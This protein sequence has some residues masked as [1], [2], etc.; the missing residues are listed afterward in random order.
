MVSGPARPNALMERSVGEV[1]LLVG[2]NQSSMVVSTISRHAE[3]DFGTPR[4]RGNIQ[5]VQLSIVLGGR[6]KVPMERFLERSKR[7]PTV[8]KRSK[9]VLLV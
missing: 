2:V 5:I 6:Q 9:G 7:R 4:V 8:A 1:W 3:C